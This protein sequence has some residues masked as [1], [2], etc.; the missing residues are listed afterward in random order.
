MDTPHIYEAM[1]A[2]YSDFTEM[3]R[4]RAEVTPMKRMGEGWDI[5][6]A[7][8]FLASDEAKYVTGIALP[9]DAGMSIQPPG[10]PPIAS[11]RLAEQSS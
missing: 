9:V 6:Y 7:A 11:Q 2:H 1:K 10:V 8:L 5:A 3:Q 4:K